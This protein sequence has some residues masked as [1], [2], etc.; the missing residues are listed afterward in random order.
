MDLT[1]EYSKNGVEEAE[2]TN[3][4]LFSILIEFLI[5]TECYDLLFESIMPK[6]LE[7]LN[8]NNNF[9]IACLQPFLVAKKV[10]YIPE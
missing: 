9:F 6:T 5:T 7:I 3:K 8:D 4:I 1:D 2:K 10:K